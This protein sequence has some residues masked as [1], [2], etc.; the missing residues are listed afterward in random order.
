MRFIDRVNELTRAEKLG[1][2]LLTL[3]HLLAAYH[4]FGFHHPDEHFQIWE[5]AHSYLGLSDPAHLPWEYNAQIRPW[6][7]PFL[8]ALVMKAALLLNAYN[9][10][11]IAWLCRAAYALANVSALFA[12]W[13]SFRERFRL[14]DG[15]F[16]ATSMLWF[17]PYIHART[18]SENLSGIFLVFA[19][20]Q[21]WKPA[22]R[23][24]RA[25]LLFG[26]AFLARYQIALG[27]AGVAV[28]L[29]IQ[30]RRILADHW[31]LAAG[32]L[33]PVGLGIVLDRIG[34]GNWVVTSY[35]YFTVNLVQ[36]VAATFNPYPWYQY[37]IWIA[38]LVP[39]VSI[40]LFAGYT[41]YIARRPVD[42][43]SGFT[44]L[45]FF[46]HL[47][48]TNKEYRF[49]FPILNFVPMMT[50]VAFPGWARLFRSRVFWVLYG[51]LSFACFGFSA[52]RGASITTLWAGHEVGHYNEPGDYWV[53]NNNF[54]NGA[55]TEFYNLTG[56]PFTL[57]NTPPEMQAAIRAHAPV[58]LIIDGKYEDQ[59][60]QEFIAVAAA[61][62]C[63]V[64]DSA[65]PLWVYGFAD[66]IPAV[67]R[68]TY[69]TY[70]AC[71]RR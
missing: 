24:F 41:R 32:F 4:S 50:A 35:R 9:Q 13:R 29:L 38:Q 66:R 11:T 71:P 7:Q 15:W 18:S 25:G 70:S 64:R 60:T 34:Y 68:L 36:G 57:T 21:L 28:V 23:F 40:P 17:F 42:L 69:K 37:F 45:F 44:F 46:L 55:K 58:K 31:R 27:L 52:L 48:I 16:V 26:F 65:Y 56:L 62:G 59:I 20:L 39:F 22:P 51:I 3:G 49:L 43:L 47:F 10:F 1:L 54:I 53:S 5:F 63:E 12:L 30:A 67:R 8:H 14:D 19:F 2:A 33:I 6:F 61:E